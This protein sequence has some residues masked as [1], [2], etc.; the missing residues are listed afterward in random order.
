MWFGVCANKYTLHLAVVISGNEGKVSSAA[1]AL[2]AHVQDKVN[3]NL[4]YRY[5]SH[6]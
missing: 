4:I 2:F 1:V 6:K 3:G 5:F